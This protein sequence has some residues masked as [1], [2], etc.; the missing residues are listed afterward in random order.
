[1][2][3]TSQDLAVIRKVAADYLAIACS[4]TINLTEGKT[5]RKKGMPYYVRKTL[6]TEFFLYVGDTTV[7]ENIMV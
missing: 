7:S 4:P 3:S 1:M 5:Y 2:P 6:A